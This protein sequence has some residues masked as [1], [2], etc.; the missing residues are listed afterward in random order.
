MLIVAVACVASVSIRVLTVM[1]PPKLA[2]VWPEAKWVADPTMAMLRL[3]CPC[4]PEAGVRLL[5]AAGPAVIVKRLPPLAVS[6]LVVTETFC[7]PRFA[8][9]LIVM[10]AVA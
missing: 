4:V 10:L 1:P 3:L 8:V 2:E 6:V 5:I 9:G 7:P